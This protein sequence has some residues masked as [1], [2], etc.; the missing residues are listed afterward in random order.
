MRP[1]GWL[2]CLFCARFPQSIH[3]PIHDRPLQAREPYGI[4]KGNE[5]SATGPEHVPLLPLSSAIFTQ[6]A[7]HERYKHES[8]R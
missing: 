2:G 4:K 1:T 8:R 6:G 5:A 7:C 3:A